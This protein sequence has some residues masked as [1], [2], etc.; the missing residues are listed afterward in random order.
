MNTEAVNQF[1]LKITEDPQ[2]QE[3]FAKALGTGNDLQAAT[4]FAVKHGYQFTPDEL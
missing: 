3:K 1:L 2:L 4:D